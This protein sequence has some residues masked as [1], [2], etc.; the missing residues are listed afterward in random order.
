MNALARLKATSKPSVSSNRGNE[1]GVE[2]REQQQQEGEEDED[3][4]TALEASRLETIANVTSAELAH[5][6][7]ARNDDVAQLARSLLDSQ[8][9]LHS[10]ALARLTA[11]RAHFDD[12]N[13][14]LLGQMGPRLP[15]VLE[16]RSAN[17]PAVATAAE[18]G[19]GATAAAMDY[20][21]P[22]SFAVAPTEGPG[23][24]VLPQPSNW[25]VPESALG[26][27]GRQAGH[28]SA[29]ATEGMERVL[30]WKAS[31]ERRLTSQ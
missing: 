5:Y 17:T 28:A 8:I 23:S 16:W 29:L 1:A 26:M 13:L 10:R 2:G 3:P 31:P 7:S 27:L 11:A 21:S 4:Q 25:C 14:E 20:F 22:S 15:S 9:N 24:G 6:H 12:S 18:R 19:G 30:P